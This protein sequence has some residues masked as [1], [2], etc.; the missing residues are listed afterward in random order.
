MDVKSAGTSGSSTVTTTFNIDSGGSWTTTSGVTNNGLINLNTGGKWT[1]PNAL[2]AL[3]NNGTV[4]LSGGTLQGPTGFFN[5][6]GMFGAGKFNVTADSTLA[7]N[8]S[9]NSL[10]NTFNIGVRSYHTLNLDTATLSTVRQCAA[11]PLS[12]PAAP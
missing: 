9:W 2:T 10:G 6:A 3:T 12:A 4:A 8:F 7:G 11:L 5:T 1:L